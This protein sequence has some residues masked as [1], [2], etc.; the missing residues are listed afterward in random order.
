[1][2]LN[3]VFSIS[4]IFFGVLSC[5]LVWRVYSLSNL[6]RTL[7]EFCSKQ[8]E[9]LETV[10]ETKYQNF[11]SNLKRLSNHNQRIA[12]LE[13][14][15]VNQKEEDDEVLVE[16]TVKESP[17]LNMTERRHRVL[18]LVSRG[19]SVEAISNTLGML[20]GEVELIVKFNR[21]AA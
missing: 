6:N 17:K 2:E 4:A 5:V 7:L 1:M 19:H 12:W 13:K 20:P 16:T 8:I 18:T 3:L 14:Q 9:D 21:I 11:E 10:S 15:V